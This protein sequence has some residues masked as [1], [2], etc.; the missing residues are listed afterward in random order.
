MNAMIRISP[1]HFG[2]AKESTSQPA[3]A[4][5]ALLPLALDL[6]EVR[7]EQ[8]VQGRVARAPRAITRLA[9]AGVRG[10]RQSPFA[11]GHHKPSARVIVAAID[12]V[13]AGKE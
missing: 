5:E 7:L 11:R 9:I 10:T 8:A 2:H 1:P 3:P 13:T 6:V 12:V 4:F